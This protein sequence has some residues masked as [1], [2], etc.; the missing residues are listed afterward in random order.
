M[1]RPASFR[2]WVVRRL[3]YQIDLQD[4]SVAA[5][6]KEMG[7]SRG[8]LADALRGEKRLSLESLLEVLE[9]LDIDPAEFFSGRT[10]EEERWTAYPRPAEGEPATGIAERLGGAMSGK[11]Q[12][13]AR[14]LVIAVIRVLEAKGLLDQDELLSALAQKKG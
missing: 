12:E 4:K 6:E 5:V 3:R 8:Y 11:S 1:D 7:R 9:H 13:D 2:E 14:S 10:A